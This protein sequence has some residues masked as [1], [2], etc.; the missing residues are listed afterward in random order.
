MVATRGQTSRVDGI[1]ASV[2]ASGTRIPR[3]NT[4]HNVTPP[5]HNEDIPD[6]HQVL[7]QMQAMQSRLARTEQELLNV[8]AERDALLDRSE[9]SGD[10]RNSSSRRSR[11]NHEIST[12]RS[13]TTPTYESGPIPRNN[14]HVGGGESGC[15]FKFKTFLDCKPI[16]FKG[17]SDPVV[18]IRW[19]REMEVVFESCDCPESKK[20]LF[21]SRMLKGDALDWWDTRRE[22]LGVEFV[23]NM[24]WESFKELYKKE[25]CTTR[26]QRLLE[27]EFLTLK[28]GDKTINEYA[29]LFMEKLRF[30][31]HLCRDEEAR[32]SRYVL[33]LPA[34]YR[35]FCRRTKTLAE[36][37]EE[38]KSVDDDLKSRV[39]KDGNT[40]FKR[41][42]EGSSG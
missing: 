5:R 33:G 2:T 15:V 3:T 23:A 4:G 37:I 38:S 8:R 16:E 7:E 27:Q 42:S 10:S 30:C 40:G 18:S 32:V 29:R 24:T 9:R 22:A 39:R 36:A 14:R 1:E 21:A 34:E 17:S 28:K 35:G 13:Q 25:Y 41:R 31:G 11:R 20:V 6:F 26:D 12:T 19:L